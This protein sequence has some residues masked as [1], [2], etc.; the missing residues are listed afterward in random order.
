MVWHIVSVW[1]SGGFF[2]WVASRLAG[3]W[4]RSPQFG[5]VH[6]PPQWPITDKFLQ[7]LV[8]Q[9]LLERLVSVR[10]GW[11]IKYSDMQ[12][13]DISAAFDRVIPRGI[14]FKLFFVGVESSVL[15]VL[16]RFLSNQSQHVTLDGCRIK[17]INV[18]PGV[19]TWDYVVPLPGKCIEIAVVPPVHRGA[20]LQ[21]E[22]H[23]LRY[24]W[25]H[26]FGCCCAIPLVRE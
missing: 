23:A 14:L 7:T 12:T 26:H 18:V 21:T 6:S 24:C 10:L 9:K 20:F 4:L 5:K 22:E 16:T 25:L 13:I 1:F 11:Y 19:V 3:E 17:L 15:S 8:H 2:V